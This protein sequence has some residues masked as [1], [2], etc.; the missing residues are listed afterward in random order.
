MVVAGSRFSPAYGAGPT[1]PNPSAAPP[2]SSSP[3]PSRRESFAVGAAFALGAALCWSLAGVI[4]RGLDLPEIEIAFWRSLFMLAALLPLLWWKRAEAR[5]DAVQSGRVLLASGALLAVTF[6]AFIVSLGMT[7]VANVL[8]L[9]GVG[10]FFTALLARVALGEA[11]RPATLAA[12]AVAAVGVATTVVDSVRVGDTAGL[13]VALVVP[14]A[15]AANTVLMRRHRAVGPLPALVLAALF[16][17]VATL[18][19]VRLGAIET[20]HLPRLLML[21]PVQLA[22]GLWLFTMALRRLPAAQAALLAIVEMALGPLW[23]WLVYAETPTPLS[24]VGGALVL[25]AVVG[26]GLAELRREIRP[27]PPAAP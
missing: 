2:M 1:A 11:V 8:F 17:V 13:L 9:M 20:G 6:V 3:V 14:L 27:P 7:T 26:N 5:R 19:F 21:G 25:A 12:M 10:P 22:L 15:F 24:L 16:S 18:P 4:V 23:V